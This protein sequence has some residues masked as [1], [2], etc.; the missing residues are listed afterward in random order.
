MLKEANTCSVFPLG[1]E[2]ADLAGGDLGA[3]HA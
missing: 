2:S 3:S 1:V